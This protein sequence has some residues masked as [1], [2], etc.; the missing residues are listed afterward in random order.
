MT[1][2]EILSKRI[3]ALC[4]ERNL[5]VRALAKKSGLSQSTLDDIVN[6]KIYSPGIE[7]IKLISFGLDISHLEFLDFSALND[8]SFESAL[9]MKKEQVAKRKRQ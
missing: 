8:L 9:Q 2:S 6:H 5:S 1:Y 7:I 4:E 3:L